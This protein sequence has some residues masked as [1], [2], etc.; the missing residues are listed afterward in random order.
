MFCRFSRTRTSDGFALDGSF[1]M[2]SVSSRIACSR[3]F[4]CATRLFV[5]Q[6]RTNGENTGA[7]RWETGT[8]GGENRR[9][10]NPSSPVGTCFRD[11]IEFGWGKQPIASSSSASKTSTIASEPFVQPKTSHTHKHPHTHDWPRKHTRI[12]AG[13]LLSKIVIPAPQLWPNARERCLSWTKK[14]KTRQLCW[15]Q[16]RQKIIDAS[17]HQQHEPY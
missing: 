12:R 3:P 9:R 4:A 10:K 5:L 6:R 16:Q 17:S 2:A 11:C 15:R 7:E 14:M 13:Q 8:G 1:F